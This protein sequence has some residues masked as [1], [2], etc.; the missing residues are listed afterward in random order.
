MGIR[1]LHLSDLHLGSSHGHL[2]SAGEAR[3]REVSDT[4]RRAITWALDPEHRIDAVILAGNVFE[5]HA[6]DPEVWALVRGLLGRLV[7]AKKRVFALPGHRDS[8]SY[9]D[10]IF[11][12]ERWPGVDLFMESHP[13]APL[14]TEIAGETVH[15]YG[16][17]W[18]AG[19]SAESFP[20][21][22]RIQADGI[23]VGLLAAVPVDHTESDVRSHDQ[24]IDRAV[25]ADSG[26]D[27]FAGGGVHEFTVF[28]A[29]GT[30]AAW[31]GT[32]EGRRFEA[33][34]F[35]RKYLLVA[36]VSPGSV[37]LEQV[38]F[39]A[40]V[41][42]HAALDLAA[43][44][45]RDETALAAAIIARAGLDRITRVS[46]HGSL[47]FLPDLAELQ[48]QLQKHFHWLEIQDQATLRGS[49]LLRRLQAENTI[50]GIFARRMTKKLD[51]A[52]ARLTRSQRGAAEDLMVLERATRLGLEQFLDVEEGPSPL[53]SR[54]RE[55]TS[56]SRE[57]PAPSPTPRLR[58]DPARSHEEGAS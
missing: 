47:E 32:L 6:P 54:G 11:R 16:A 36:D 18:Q 44:D 13:T 50:R 23:H 22:T 37:Q 4:F 46:L 39:S 25:I 33:G 38:P 20:G 31:P 27:Y 57:V 1:F 42:E 10:S 51:E 21:F 30:T 55:E 19:K 56:E 12:T 17:A 2:G 15:L 58:V 34:D 35:G 48:S 14:T 24:T 3:A 49:A 45:I 52:T 28:Q 40:K 43:E 29:G 9:R 8:V 5:R 53:Y 7:A 41:V 26:L